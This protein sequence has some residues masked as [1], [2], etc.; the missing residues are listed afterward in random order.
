MARG[1]GDEGCRRLGARGCPLNHAQ[2]SRGYQGYHCVD[3]IKI[4][5][6]RRGKVRTRD[7]GVVR[8]SIDINMNRRDDPVE[9]VGDQTGRERVTSGGIEQP[10]RL[11]DYYFDVLY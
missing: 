7:R 2:K 10:S 6:I 1:E 11:S 8:D 9:G 3:W 4:I 5:V